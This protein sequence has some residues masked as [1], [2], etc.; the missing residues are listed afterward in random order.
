M[1]APIP[2]KKNEITDPTVGRLVAYRRL[3]LALDNQKVHLVSSKDIGEML[4]IKPSQ[5]RKDLSYLGEFGKR[6][7]GYNVRRLLSD[8]S[9]I[10]APFCRW[11]VGLIGLGRLGEALLGY[12]AMM[13][14]SYE[15]VA[16]FDVSPEKVGRSFNGKACWHSDQLAAQIVEQDISVLILTVPPN[17]AQQIVDAA[18]AT[19]RI[20]GIL[21][22]SPTIITVPDKV[23]IQYVDISVEME[24]LLFR[25]KFA[26]Q[27]REQ[28]SSGVVQ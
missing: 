26:Q 17:A 16:L 9:G 1:S 12:S 24:K 6:G 25:L 28:R 18:V 27:Q 14:E 21:N 19:E 15:I 23:E 11:R 10:L 8:L 22:F 3:L 7:V 5:V 2:L 4:A 20:S 13:G